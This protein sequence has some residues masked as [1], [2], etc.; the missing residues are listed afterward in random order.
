MERTF[1]RV[2]G[3]LYRTLNVGKQTVFEDQEIEHR[4]AAVDNRFTTKEVADLP[5]FNDTTI[6]SVGYIKK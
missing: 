1:T 6:K 4:V 3:R 2:N 5:F